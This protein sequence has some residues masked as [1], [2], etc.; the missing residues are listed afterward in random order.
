[1]LRSILGGKDNPCNRG[2]P[3]ECGSIVRLQHVQTRKYLHSH[4]FKSPLSNQQEVSAFGGDA[5]SDT[6]DHWM[7]Y[8]KTR[9]WQK[10]ET[11]RFK[12]VDTDTWISLSGNTYGRPIFGQLEVI[13]STSGTD[14]SSYWKT[15]EG[16]YVEPTVK[17]TSSEHDE[18]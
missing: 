1:M 14:S 8:C 17:T 4:L 5:D 11:V 12:H 13:C 7:V 10:G 6:G 15:A 2:E 9:Y 18:L 16:V 3:I